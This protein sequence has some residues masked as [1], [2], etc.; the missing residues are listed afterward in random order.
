MTIP[1]KL[2]WTVYHSFQ[3][4][5]SAIQ[6]HQFTPI[7]SRQLK[8]PSIGTPMLGRLEGELWSLPRLRS[9]K[10]IIALIVESRMRCPWLQSARKLTGPLS[11]RNENAHPSRAETLPRFTVFPISPRARRWPKGWRASPEIRSNAP[12]KSVDAAKNNNVSRWT[13]HS[14]SLNEWTHFS[15]SSNVSRPT[16]KY[17]YTIIMCWNQPC[18]FEYEHY[19][20]TRLLQPQRNLEVTPCTYP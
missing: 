13:L 8:H 15:Y 3:K 4:H 6:L 10:I 18:W 9:A 5:S 16:G 1:S 14:P 12:K 20:R 2:P 17:P 7:V 19:E 11:K